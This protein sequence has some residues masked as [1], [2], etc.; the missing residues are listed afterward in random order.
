MR[1]RIRILSFMVLCFYLAGCGGYRAIKNPGPDVP[2]GPYESLAVKAGDEV[3]VALV[4]GT[5]LEGVVVS[6]DCESLTIDEKIESIDA[7]ADDEIAGTNRIAI[8]GE[9]RDL[10]IA[11]I[12]SLDRYEPNTA[13]TVALVVVGVGVVA[14]GLALKSVGDSFN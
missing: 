7:E 1:K 4:D 5:T 6:S 11:E 14:V 3:R 8:T 9:R 12:A 10:P 2:V 13:G